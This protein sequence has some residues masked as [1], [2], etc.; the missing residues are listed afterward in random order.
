MSTKVGVW[1]SEAGSELLSTFEIPAF[2]G[3]VA[4]CAIRTG[5]FRFDDA[6]LRLET[7]LCRTF[8]DWC[9]KALVLYLG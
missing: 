5:A 1:L 2:S 7:D 4:K 6:A 9:F 3:R 8:G